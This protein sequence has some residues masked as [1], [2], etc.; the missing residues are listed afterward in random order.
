MR[1]KDKKEKEYIKWGNWV[2]KDMSLLCFS[3]FFM[4]QEMPLFL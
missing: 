2:W 1:E 4:V 3:N